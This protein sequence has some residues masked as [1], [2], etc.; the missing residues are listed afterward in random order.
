MV[1]PPIPS[2]FGT[3]A[4]ED[5]RQSMR[6]HHTQ[7]GRGSTDTALAMALTQYGR[8]IT[9]NPVYDFSI[10]DLSRLKSGLKEHLRMQDWDVLFHVLP[11]FRDLF[12]QRLL[13]YV[14]NPP[15]S[16]RMECDSEWIA[17]SK[18]RAWGLSLERPIDIRVPAV[19]LDQAVLDLWASDTLDDIP[20]NRP[21]TIAVS[22]GHA[23][24]FGFVE[25][26]RLRSEARE[27]A[28]LGELS[29]VALNDMGRS[30]EDARYNATKIVSGVGWQLGAHSNGTPLKHEL[31]IVH[32][33][34][35]HLVDA[36]DLVVLG[37]GNQD[38]FVAQL[39]RQH[40]KRTDKQRDAFLG[41]YGGIPIRD[42]ALDESA[43]PAAAKQQL[44]QERLDH[45]L[46]PGSGTRV[47]ALI[48]QES[49]LDAAE[50]VLRRGWAHRV[51]LGRELADSL[52]RR[53]FPKDENPPAASE[54][55]SDPPQ[56]P[57]SSTPS[58]PAESA[59]SKVKSAKSG[60]RR[61][62]PRKTQRR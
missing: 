57:P 37:A 25:L 8:W 23:Q 22:G 43:V 40:A 46:R 58:A 50:L 34:Y 42:G 51:Y 39:A 56:S 60:T 36:P 30:D 53:M 47:V 6:N 54:T 62:P 55:L 5:L 13:R 48:P 41:D 31:P 24:Y 45:W 26:L 14:G 17:T 32:S 15:R 52:C 4:L 49:K 7:R 12:C 27:Y 33:R 9:R 3:G 16:R 61:V 2:C 21:Y 28:A 10:Y 38:G 1:Q 11:E 29:L 44:T 19:N 20:E 35:R 18:L 59:T